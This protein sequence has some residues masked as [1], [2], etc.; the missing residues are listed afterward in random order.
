V[1]GAVG[2]PVN[3][4]IA[5]AAASG[6]AIIADFAV[7]VAASAAVP[8][9]RATPHP[10]ALW[11]RSGRATLPTMRTLCMQMSGVVSDSVFVCDSLTRRVFVALC[12]WTSRKRFPVPRT[13]VIALR[14][15]EPL[16]NTLC[17]TLAVRCGGSASVNTADGCAPQ[18]VPSRI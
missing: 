12:R 17:G 11:L 9:L 16:E 2:C 6:A 8:A 5:V 4:A 1:A 14:G 10:A 13:L 15:D 3:F 7:A 18:A